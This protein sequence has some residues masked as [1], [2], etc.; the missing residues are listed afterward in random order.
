MKGAYRVIVFTGESLEQLLA[1]GKTGNWKAKRESLEKRRF[2]IATHNR[3]A[4]W[5]DRKGDHG[6][7][8]LVGRIVNIEE[9]PEPW[10]KAIVF[11][12]YA[13]V[14]IPAAWPTGNRNPV[15]YIKLSTLGIDPGKLEWKQV[16]RREQ[17]ISTDTSLVA[18]PADVIDQARKMIARAFAIRPAA[19]RISAEL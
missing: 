10:R 13:L 17:A 19:V 1:N 8:F 6:A 11:D 2:V 4:E 14:D 12:Q 15:A 5:G 3:R 16:E 7:A 18:A 9:S